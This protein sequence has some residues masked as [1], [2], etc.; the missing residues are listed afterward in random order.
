MTIHLP[1]F[2]PP[3]APDTPRASRRATLIGLCAVGAS[4]G[5]GLASG[6]ASPAAG[7]SSPDPIFAAIDAHR[8]ALEQYDAAHAHFDAM[9]ALYPVEKDP[10]EFWDWTV[11]QRTAWRDGQRERY[12]GTPR[13]I[14]YDRWN[15]Q[16]TAMNEATEALVD[17][18]PATIAGAAAVLEYWT[19]FSARL[20]ESSD[21]DFLE[22]D[23][24]SRV[25]TGVVALLR[26]VIERGLS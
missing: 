6:L 17:A 13:N 3:L 4:I 22:L 15:D 14:A 11:E 9:N 24:H 18:S 5:P 20:D 16:C 12:E 21:F 26:S 7:H 8:V 25:M 1:M 2:P 10:D 19:E 23:C